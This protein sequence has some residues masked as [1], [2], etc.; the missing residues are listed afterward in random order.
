MSTSVRVRVSADDRLLAP[1]RQHWRWTLLGVL[2]AAMATA[3]RFAAIGILPPSFK[4]KP[5]AR[6]QAST[7][8][9][10]GDASR[11]TSGARDR[12]ASLIAP[13]AYALADM[14]NSPQLIEYVA[15]QAGLPASKIGILGPLWT[16]SW[17]LQEWPTGPKR[18]SQILS[19]HALYQITIDQE[20][21]QPPWSP[22][23]GVYAK[24]PS[25]EAA[26]RLASAVPAGLSAYMQQL[27]ATGHVPVGDRYEVSQLGPV[28]VAPARGSQL[29]N[30]GVFTFLGTF[31]LWCGA[32][33]AISSLV[34]DL[35]ATAT[36]SKVEGRSERSSDNGRIVGDH[37][38]A[39]T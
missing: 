1:L 8:V 35:R 36:A 24:A 3:T 18:A 4:M 2:V 19:E 25:A 33:I 37:A 21:A 32:V 26:A 7:T 23:I 9:V 31:V 29:A 15:R 16:D 14:L 38:N 6:A 30:V 13:R 28:S 22:A 27:Q 10:L 11:L 39:T 5:F 20:A 12:Y 34:R 17:R